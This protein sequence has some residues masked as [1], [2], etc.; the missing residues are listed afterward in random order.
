M[1]VEFLGCVL[2]MVVYLPSP[3]RGGVG[4]DLL[5]NAEKH[6]K[7]EVGSSNPKEFDGSSP[8]GLTQQPLCI[9][10]K[11]NRSPRL[12]KEEKV[13]SPFVLAPGRATVVAADGGPLPSLS[14]IVWRE[15][16]HLEEI[17][18]SPC[19]PFVAGIHMA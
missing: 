13:R 7:P 2:M 8:V 10:G 4:D 17:A 19:L 18:P 5:Q 3:L 1:L 9:T 14:N 12:K 16:L 15:S 11:P 6:V